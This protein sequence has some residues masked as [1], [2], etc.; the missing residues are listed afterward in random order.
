[1]ELH[2]HAM[3]E[4]GYEGGALRLLEQVYEWGYTHV[5]HSGY[6]SH[7]LMPALVDQIHVAKHGHTLNDCHAEAVLNIPQTLFSPGR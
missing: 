3:E 2:P 7:L 5:S 6:A 4:A 1:M